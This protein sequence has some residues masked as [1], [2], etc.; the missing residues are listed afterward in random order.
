MTLVT[1][2][3]LHGFA[4]PL[5]AGW[6]LAAN[7]G[8]WRAGRLVLAD[9]LRAHV[10]L[11][12][13]RSSRT[14]DLA[15]TLA[16]AG[17][18]L[19]RAHPGAGMWDHRFESDRGFACWRAHD[20]DRHVAVRRFACG[21][22]LVWQQVH[23]GSERDL[24]KL[25]DATTAVA[26]DQP[27]PWRLH[28]LD[29]ELPPWWRLE[30]VQHVAGLVRALWCRYP[31]DRVRPDQLLVVRRIACAHVV[32]GERTLDAWLRAHLRR[33]EVA[34]SGRDGDVAMVE[35]TAPGPTWWR[36]LRRQHDRRRLHAWIEDDAD[37]LVIQEWKGSTGPLPCLL[38]LPGSALRVA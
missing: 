30:G 29:L 4:H 35:A 25:V 2:I 14:P 37:R 13:A 1:A 19:A 24:E 10:Q 23:P 3:A 17:K 9:E 7:W 8:N 20:G 27:A 26:N 18:K 38:R 31:D 28:G 5:P 21:V 36:R 12:W 32:L 15:A 16:R 34:T 33:S 22:S 11:S 6:E